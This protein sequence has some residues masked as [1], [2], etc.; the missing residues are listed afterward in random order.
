MK[1]DTTCER[2]GSISISY[3]VDGT[4]LVNEMPGDSS[5]VFADSELISSFAKLISGTSAY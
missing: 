1:S 2:T 4:S 3:I 5:N